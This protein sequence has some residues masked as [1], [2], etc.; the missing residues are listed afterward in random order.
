MNSRIL[1]V[2]L[3]GF[4]LWAFHASAQDA[5]ESPLEIELKAFLFS[6]GERG[7]LLSEDAEIMPGQIIEYELSYTNVSNEPLFEVNATAGIP[8]ET[9]FIDGSATQSASLEPEY[10]VDG[11]NFSTPPV[12]IDVENEDG[13]TERIEAS[14]EAYRALRWQIQELGSNES[15]SFIYRVQVD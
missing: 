13:E 9:A 11:S 15:R 4:C 5:A 12:Y 7:P 1:S 3:I 14:S 2:T 8:E 6:H 10:S